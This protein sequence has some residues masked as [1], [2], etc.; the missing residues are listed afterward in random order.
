[1]V[2]RREHFLGGWGWKWSNEASKITPGSAQKT[3]QLT[4]FHMWF[5]IFCLLYYIIIYYIIT[6]FTQ[7]GC[8][9]YHFPFMRG[10]HPLVA[11]KKTV[12]P[13]TRILIEGSLPGSTRFVLG[14]VVQY[15]DAT[16]GTGI[17]TKPLYLNWI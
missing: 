17:F 9:M 16:H 15:P 14:E 13:P 11:E 4:M 1:M 8:R 5:C 3:S 6:A 10:S 7:D 2:Q 12:A